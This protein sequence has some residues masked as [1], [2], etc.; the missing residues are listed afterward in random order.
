M[1]II[2]K[3]EHRYTLGVAYK[4]GSRLDKSTHDSQ[5]DWATG[6]VIQKAAWDFVS[7]LEKGNGLN[8]SHITTS[9]GLSVGR[10]VESFLAPVDMN[11]NG[12]L[13]K[14]NTWLVG[15]IWEPHYWQ[16]I[17]AGERL[18]LSIEGTGKRL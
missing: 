7:N 12:K 2:R 18:G 6:D 11:I 15:T 14:K 10:V 5:G 17:K 8:D 3:T 9:D 13:I 4:P 1:E 16:K